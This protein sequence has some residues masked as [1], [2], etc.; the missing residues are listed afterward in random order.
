MFPSGF[1]QVTTLSEYKGTQRRSGKSRKVTKLVQIV[2]KAVRN[3]IMVGE[4]IA[5]E[6]PEFQVICRGGGGGLAA[7]R[8]YI[9]IQCL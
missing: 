2:D 5:N 9:M 3:F 8:P 6:N 7:I 1:S 4:E